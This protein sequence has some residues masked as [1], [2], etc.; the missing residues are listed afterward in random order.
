MRG[1]RRTL[2]ALA[3]L[4]LAGLAA[5]LT[6]AFRSPS[7]GSPSGG[8]LTSANYSQWGV[9][10][11]YPATWTRLDCT[12]WAGYLQNGKRYGLFAPI[13]FLT[14]A[15]PPPTCGAPLTTF[16]PPERLG[17]GGA[18]VVLSYGPSLG[19]K[20]KESFNGQPAFIRRPTFG[21]ASYLGAQE[22]STVPCPAGGRRESRA[23]Y[24]KRQ[25]PHSMFTIAALTC[26]PNLAT[27]DA[28]VR[29][30]LASMSF[31]KP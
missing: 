14:S 1:K 28:A 29:N 27:A 7:G 24:I 15:Q 17:P 16:P 12:S 26:G 25:T 6:F 3:L 10:L 11:R 18:I 31:A 21:T 8:G 30:V 13:S 4:L 20:W 23:V 5:G 9:S 22:L 19:L 2:I